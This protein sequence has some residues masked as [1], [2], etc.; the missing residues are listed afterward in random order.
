MN[1][2]HSP[3]CLL[4]TGALVIGCV[5]QSVAFNDAAS[6]IQIIEAAGKV[7]SVTVYRGQALVTRRVEFGGAAGLKELI[8][9]DLPAHAVATSLHA[10]AA[11]GVL[12]R[13]VRYRERPVPVDVRGEVEQLEQQITSLRDDLARAENQARSVAQRSAY[14]DR[15]EQFSGDG[16]MKDLSHGVLD[17]A[18]LK[19]LSAYLFEQRDALAQESMEITFMQ[20]DLK[21]QI[22]L[23]QRELRT[24]GARSTRTAREAVILVDAQRA[25]NAHVDLFYLV[26]RA[27]WTPSYT[28]RGDL[29]QSQV[30]IEY[31]ASIEQTSG[32]DWS[33]VNMT[34]ST[35]TPSLV[36]RAPVL[37]ALQV[38]L[39]PMAA[40]PP[41]PPAGRRELLMQQRGAERERAAAGGGGGGG[42]GGGLFGDPGKSFES[43][44]YQ[45][46]T[47][48]DQMQLL[49]LTGRDRS[50]RE[51]VVVA[52][53]GHSVTYTIAGRTSLPSRSGQQLIQ[54]A[55]TPLAGEF[56]QVAIPVLT[57]YVYEEAA[58][59]NRTGHVLLAGPVSTYAGGQFVGH[60][61][62]DDTAA[63]EAMTIGLGINSL[64]RSERNVLKQ[65]ER[66][67][68]GNRVVDITYRLTVQNFGDEPAAIRL[69]DRLPQVRPNEIKLTIVD[70]GAA[71]GQ[72]RRH[73][74]DAASGILTWDVQVPAG[75]T[76]A[77]ALAVDYTIRLEYDRT[78]TIAGIR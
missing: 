25:G 29:R 75:A 74:H 57:T 66:I 64:V 3:L 38:Q 34:L 16:A 51:P 22:D 36:S 72:V 46:N 52:D 62:F 60:S 18:S 63:G 1:K 42:G 15:L 17:A 7:D 48:A 56:Y 33:N 11:P 13:S 26:D 10:E 58:V 45:M 27:T 39:Q 37:T 70:D 4:L 40:A 32:E 2:V 77:D 47:I 41:A 65:D 67:Q 28:V 54:I 8:V 43:Y 20:R 59:S 55:A 14:L 9:T 53:E 50:P 24:L 6:D 61:S 49:E 68:G 30:L 44:D 73:V 5:E 78:M 76:G 12:I 31:F 19:E 23:L 21:A 35:A 69:K 71:N